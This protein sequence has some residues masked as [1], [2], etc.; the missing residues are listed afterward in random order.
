MRE[1][2]KE[3]RRIQK[4]KKELEHEIE[5]K[6]KIYASLEEIKQDERA[7]RSVE[8]DLHPTKAKKIAKA[9]GKALAGL[10]KGKANYMEAYKAQHQTELHAVH[11]RKM[12]EVA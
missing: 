8:S 9:L 7:L 11:R 2:D 12:N 6:R 3:L 5:T 4:D 10:K 1:V